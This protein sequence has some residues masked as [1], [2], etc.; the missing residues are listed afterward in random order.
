MKFRLLKHVSFSRPR[1]I[2]NK[3]L[4]KQIKA[5]YGI[6][7]RRL[8]NFTLCG[9][10]AVAKL[11]EDL[12]S[13]KSLSLISCAQYFSVELV[14]QML[15]EIEQNK[16]VRPLDFVSTVGNAANYYIAKE[17]S[18]FG[19]NLF[20]GADHNALQ[21]TLTVATLELDNTPSHATVILIWRETE[22]F[23]VCH[24]LLITSCNDLDDATSLAT[25]EAIDSISTLS[26]PCD[27]MIAPIA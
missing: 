6:D 14:Q 16:A 12:A 1:E 13:F 23:R 26:V 25:L 22:E 21:K 19:S 20:F 8:D 3:T 5:E 15:T 11:K 17:F 2:E 4:R 18:I 24:A 9:L 7:G 10:S 27:L